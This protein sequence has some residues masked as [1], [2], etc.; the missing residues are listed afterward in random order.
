MSSRGVVGGRREKHTNP[1]KKA[2]RTEALV[3][4]QGGERDIKWSEG[5]I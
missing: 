3:D 1:R 5:A 4:S 2:G